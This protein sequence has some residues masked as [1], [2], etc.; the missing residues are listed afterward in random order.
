MNIKTTLNV[1]IG[2]FVMAGILIFLSPA[3]PIK[4]SAAVSVP[5]LGA[6]VFYLI[7]AGIIE[8]DKQVESYRYEL[9]IAQE[10]M[11]Q[12]RLDYEDSQNID[13][14]TKCHN[15]AYFQQEALRFIALNNRS[16]VGFSVILLRIDRFSEVL[17][18]D[19]QQGGNE[20]LKIMASLLSRGV[21]ETDVVSRQSD[22][23]F[24]LLLSDAVGSDA[25]LVAE[26]LMS[27][28]RQIRHRG[29]GAGALT[30]SITV[31]MGVT[32]YRKQGEVDVMLSE[33]E[34]A[35]KVATKAGGDRIAVF[36]EPES[37]AA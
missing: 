2:L 30:V 16:G 35:I 6:A 10:R 36:A 20:L 29:I 24:A 11:A 19:G 4:L 22:E 27:L 37:V 17:E 15:P 9:A 3:D 25:V 21:R 33:A 26:R 14:L 5:A 31:S 23:T 8:T 1:G 7:R 18:Q 12:L 34:E 13:H 28:A 32:S